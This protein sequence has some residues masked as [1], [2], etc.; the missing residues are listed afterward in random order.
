[1]EN[2]T[3]VDQGEPR[4][5]TEAE[6]R[7][8]AAEWAAE[9]AARE[10]RA[11]AER[12]RAARA[13]AA[14]E[15]AER[16]EEVERRESADRDRLRRE[17]EEQEARLAVSRRRFQRR[18][19]T[20]LAATVVGIAVIAAILLWP[21][22]AFPSHSLFSVRAEGFGVVD[23][24]PDF[25]EEVVGEDMRARDGDIWVAGDTA[26]VRLDDTGR[27]VANL[28]IDPPLSDFAFSDTQ[29]AWVVHAGV[30][31]EIDT[32]ANELRDDTPLDA[33]PTDVVIGLGYVWVLGLSG[34]DVEIPDVVIRLDPDGGNPRLVQDAAGLGFAGGVDIASNASAIW[35]ADRSARRVIKIDPGDES[36]DPRT[37]SDVTLDD[38]PD[39]IVGA[40][41]F[42]YAFNHED[43]TVTVIDPELSP[44]MKAIG[45]QPVLIRPGLGFAWTLNEDGTITR[46]DAETL[47]PEN[48]PLPVSARAM[49]VDTD[50]ELVWVVAR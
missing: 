48:V 23:R 32:D 36:E 17:A 7:R 43:G 16:R 35:V 15:E 45:H 49:T 31:T 11:R 37:L 46:V 41:G 3:D 33:I 28:E 25:G 21:E 6:A 12:D 26:V 18:T 50:Q 24:V 42:V 20:G 1:V 14:R 38:A 40:G 4:A 5:S 8:E 2:G 39:G 44:S 30:L 27:T 9:E 47:Q 13:R 34:P 22:P 19:I 10:A 29:E